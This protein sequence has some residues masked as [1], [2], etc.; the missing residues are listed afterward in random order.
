MAAAAGTT[1]YKISVSPENTGLWHVRQTEEASKKV[2]ELLQ[3]DLEKHHVFFNK[4]GFHN[5][6]SRL[7]LHPRR[8]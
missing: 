3:E 2:S 4:D 8:P 6:V 5:H 7:C 1:A